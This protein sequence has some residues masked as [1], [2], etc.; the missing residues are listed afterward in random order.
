MCV[1]CLF[2]NMSVF[3]AHESNLHDTTSTSVTLGHII[4]NILT[5]VKCCLLLTFGSEQAKQN[6]ILSSVIHHPVPVTCHESSAKHF[7]YLKSATSKLKLR[8]LF[9]KMLITRAFLI[10]TIHK[11]C[12]TVCYQFTTVFICPTHN[13]NLVPRLCGTARWALRLSA[14]VFYP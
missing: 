7:T 6:S 12:Y 13:T 14:N 10:L 5:V 3:N 2:R 8:I 4:I 1:C 11:V 9:F